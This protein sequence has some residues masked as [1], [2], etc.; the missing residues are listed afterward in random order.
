MV[1]HITDDEKYLLQRDFKKQAEMLKKIKG[2]KPLDLLRHYRTMGQEN[3][4]DIIACGFIPEKTY[5]HSNLRRMGYVACIATTRSLT[6]QRS[7]LRQRRPHG[8]GYHSL[9][10]SQH[11]WLQ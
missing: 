7:F 8:Q 5:I 4:K 11:L 2:K 6:M 3:I 9:A 1:A 10:E